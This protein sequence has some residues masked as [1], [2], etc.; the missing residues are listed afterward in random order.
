[1]AAL[2]YRE[3]MCIAVSTISVATLD[4]VEGDTIDESAFDA[5]IELWQG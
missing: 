1:M 5:L 4:L 3:E 2:S